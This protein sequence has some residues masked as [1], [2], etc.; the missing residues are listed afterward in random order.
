MAESQFIGKLSFGENR[1]FSLLF[2]SWDFEFKM[3]N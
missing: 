1:V 2:N 3:E